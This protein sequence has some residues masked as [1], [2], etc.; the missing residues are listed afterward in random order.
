MVFP[1]QGSQRIGMAKSLAESSSAASETLDEVSRS[2][3]LDIKS[4]MWDSSEDELRQTQ[5]A[6]IA[7]FAA[8]VAAFRAYD[9]KDFAYA[10]GHSVGEYAA[11]VCAGWLS[12]S[13]GAKLVQKR[14]QLMAAAGSAQPGT[15]AA[16]LGLELDK[17]EVICAH[18]VDVV[19]VANYNCPGQYVISGTL[20]GVVEASDKASA[21]GAKRVLPLN[22]SGAFHSP[23]MK[24]PAAE[25]RKTLDLASFSV[26]NVPVVSNVTALPVVENW[27]AALELQLVSPVQ[28]TNSIQWLVAQGVTEFVEFG[29]G[30]VLA[31]L[32]RRIEKSA[33]VTSF[34]D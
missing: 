14:G 25:M 16:V 9:P 5:N 24:A 10:A 12:L 11:L 30:Q 29:S 23:L 22:V 15:M 21:A 26:G 33:Q 32:I 34:G 3:G 7:L 28:W 2:V 13:E 18:C 31:G 20:A 6:Q 4:L 27:P 1:G 19:V 17:L 8:S